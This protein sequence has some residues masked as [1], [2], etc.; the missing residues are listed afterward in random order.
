MAILESNFMSFEEIKKPREANNSKA[1]RNFK[2]NGEGG[3]R[4]LAPR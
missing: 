4:T 2:R 1:F 3:I